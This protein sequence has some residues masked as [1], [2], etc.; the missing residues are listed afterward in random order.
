M[1]IHGRRDIAERTFPPPDVLAGYL[2]FLFHVILTARMMAWNNAPHEQIADLMDAVHNLPTFLAHWHDFDQELFRRSLKSYDDKW[3]GG[4]LACL[5]DRLRSA[6][7]EPRTLNPK[8]EPAMGDAESHH[9]Q[10]VAI[11]GGGF[12]GLYAAKSFRRAP[13][14]VTL[15]DRRNFHLFQPLLY[16]VA[17]GGL[18]AAN[19][20]APLR[21]VL[22]RQK[23]VRVVLADVRGFDLAGRRVLTTDG[24]IPY[25]SLIVAPGSV[26]HYFG[27]AA[28]Q[29]LAPGLKTIEN[30]T[31]IRSRIL[32]AFEAAEREP[33]AANVGPW[34]TFVVAGGGPTGVELAGT[35]AEIARGTLRG[36]FRAVDP[37]RAKIILVEGSDRVLAGHTPELSEKAQRQIEQLG[38]EVRTRTLVTDVRPGEVTVASGESTE[39]I[40]ARTVLWAAGV[41]ASPLGARLAEAA[42]LE[43]DPHG[44]VPV[45]PDLSLRG[46][47]DVFAIGDLAC[48]VHQTGKPLPGLAPVAM[49]QGRYVARLIRARLAGRTQPPFHYRDYGTMA[50]VGRARAVAMIGRLRLSGLVAWLAWLFIHL[51]YIVQFENRLLVLFQWAWNY[52]TWNRSARLITGESLIPGCNEPPNPEL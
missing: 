19:I 43:T 5:D 37:T 51:M 23:N 22:K 16:Q 6:C 24:S 7:P 30:A 33:D 47:A 36:E 28:W 13:V 50:T 8:P 39:T 10:R 4:L 1:A 14:H 34:L 27:H 25:D 46:H 9:S 11:I 29:R 31:E 42:G 48:F 12:G 20:A 38:V 3:H 45:A 40:P 2:D 49:Q 15:I 26:N 44:R 32:S 52:V 41:R 17:T 18:S 21:S 35:L